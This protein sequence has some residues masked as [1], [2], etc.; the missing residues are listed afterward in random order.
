MNHGAPV[1]RR[2]VLKGAVAALAVPAL[3]SCATSAVRLPGDPFTLGVAS[4]YPTPSG[5]VLWTRLAPDPLNGGG[6]GPISIPVEW[7]VADDERMSRVVRRGT[8]LA[9]AE[10]A[11]SVHV[12]VDGLEAGRWYWYQFRVGGYASAVARTRT[13]P[14]SGGQSPRF[15][16][17]LASC[18]QYEQ[19]YYVAYR[20]MAVEDLDLVVHVGDYIYES[21]WGRDHVRSHGTPKPVTLADYR[22]RYALYKSDP[23]LQGAHATFPWMVIWD[24]HE[25][26]NDYANDRSETLED[27]RTFLIR[28]AAAYQAYYEHM[29]LPRRMRPIN[30][31]MTIYTRAAFGDLVELHLLDD[32]QYRSHQPCPKPGRGGSNFVESCPER[33][34]PAATMLGAA[35]ERWLDDGFARAR[36]RWTVVAQQTLMAPLDRKPGPGERYWTDGWDGYTAARSRLLQSIATHKPSNPL[37]LGG[38]VH[39]CWVTDLKADFADPAAP[40]IATEFV[41]TSITSQAPRQ[42]ALAAMLPDNPHIRYVNSLYRGYLRLDLGRDDARA[43]LRAVDTVRDRNAS[44]RTLQSFAVESGQAGARLA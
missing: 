11:H 15:R 33:H 32:R 5:I 35:Q 6:L 13:A 2:G 18:Q 8:A 25:V 43:D 36:S 23:D 17:A 22:N 3:H 29:P 10:F 19:G 31:V 38:D 7:I 9:E 14:P 12:D 27:P 28:R 42:E 20:H 40:A 4:G 24:D 39:T 37:V 41:T 44:I 34:D 26:E 21:S 30:G 16:L 1:T